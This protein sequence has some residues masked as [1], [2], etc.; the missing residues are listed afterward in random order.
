[1]IPRVGE[2]VT[3]PA[4][5]RTPQGEI[6][7]RTFPSLGIFYVG[8]LS[9]ITDFLMFLPGTFGHVLSTVSFI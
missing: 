7:F 2:I 5:G 4:I 1:M 9:N 6:P 8:Q 3:R